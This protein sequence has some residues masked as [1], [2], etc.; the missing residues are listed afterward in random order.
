MKWKILI[1]LITFSLFTL[2]V[3]ANNEGRINMPALILDIILLGGIVVI[4]LGSVF[5]GE[6]KT[7]FNYIFVGL[8]IFAANHLIE[9]IT[10]T[11]GV[12]YDVSEVLHRVVHLGGFAFLIYGFYRVRNVISALQS[13]QYKKRRVK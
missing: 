12:G 11:L 7:A 10:I 3:F 9:T 13:K 8:V 1:L 4:Y 2:P 6:L 5:A